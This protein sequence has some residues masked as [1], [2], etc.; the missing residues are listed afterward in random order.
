MKKENK[1][2][3]Y[4][5]I[6]AVLLIPFMYSFFY[7]KA[8]WNP[9]GKGNIDNLPVAIVNNDEGDK[10]ESLIDSIKDSKKLK[11]S[12]VSDE[13]ATDGLNNGDYY[14]LINIPSD[15]TSSMESAK[16]ENKKHATIT[17]SPNQKSNYLASQI[18]NNVVNVVEKNLDNEINSTIVSNLESTVTSVP[19]EL[20][21]ISSGFS[22][23]STGTDK[24]KDGSSTL[25]SGTESLSNGTKEIK[26][27]LESSVNNLNS[28][29]TSTEKKEI[30]NTLSKSPELSKEN[31]ETEAMKGLESNQNYVTLKETYTNGLNNYNNGLNQ[32]NLGLNN[33]ITQLNS[34]GYSVD[35]SI[36]TTCINDSTSSPLCSNSNVLLLINTKKTLDTSKS[37]LDSLKSVIDSIELTAKTTAYETANKVSKSVAISTASSVKKNATETTKKSLNILLTYVNELDKGASLIN[38]G[39]NSLNNGLTVLNSS[40]KTSKKELDNKI[41]S[42]KNDIKKVEKISDYAKEPVKVNTEEVNEV[43]SYGTAFAP[44][45]ISIALWVGCLMMFIVLY[46]DKNERF[47][48]LGIND[49]RR[50]KRTLCYHA[51]TTVMAII[52][53]ILLQTLLDFEITNI[54]LYYLSLILVSNAFLAIIEFLISNFNDIGK[55]IALIILVLQL[56]ASG[57]TFPIETVTS[58]FRFL[59]PLLPMTYTIRLL[60]ESLIIIENPLLTK[61]LI[62]VFSIFLVFFIINLCID[63][64][65]TKK[66]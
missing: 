26:S 61:N 41:D 9:Y 56:A 53:G 18:I 49:N 28:E 66:L 47:G 43:A 60:K 40:V 57:G 35:E 19:N 24:L 44:L 4:V 34:L 36:I 12:V 7:L 33:L 13:E 51:L 15:F 25:K 59:N 65:K 29:L 63:H 50:V 5:V 45:F 52:L 17:Y 62:I 42:T 23:L 1:Y 32:Y 27:N 2:F 16:T 6:C 11:I 38:S 20:D 30:L 37:S 10:G 8:Y 55:F 3:K 54:L 46:Y 48:I 14:A 31:I 39:A 58:G 22:E 64:Y 21:K